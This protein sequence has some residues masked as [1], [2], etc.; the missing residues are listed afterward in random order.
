MHTAGC[1][2]CVISLGHLG[3]LIKAY[4]AA[5]KTLRMPVRFV[6]ETS[7]LGTAGA[8]ALLDPIPESA[9]VINCDVLSD[10]SFR[11]V[12]KQHNTRGADITI[13]SVRHK[14]KL[15][16]GVLDVKPDGSLN[17]WREGQEHLHLVSGGA[18]VVGRRALSMI[19]RGERLDMPSLVKRVMDDGGS[20][21]VYIHEGGWFDLGT[22]DSYNLGVAAFNATPERF[23]FIQAY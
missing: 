19:Q 5:N 8:L 20:A 13:L 11:D 15:P 7:P 12:I 4:C 21:Q 22:I 16:Y 2:D 23:G 10:V 1:S 14:Y 6:E 17:V 3:A 9:V 18:Y